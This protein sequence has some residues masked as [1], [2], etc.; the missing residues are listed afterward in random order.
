MYLQNKKYLRRF[1]YL[2]YLTAVT[3]LA[4]EIILR[5][6]YPFQ[7]KI[8]GNQWKLSTNVV[9]HLKNSNNPRLDPVVVN[10]RNSIGFRGENPSSYIDSQ[11]TLLTVGGSTTACT[12]LTEG[13]TWTDILGKKLQEQFPAAWINNAG[14]DGHSAYGNV[15]FLYHYLPVLHFK[16]R[17]I[18][19]LVGANDIDR[20]D[21]GSAD[22]AL[23][24][25]GMARRWLENNSETVN[26]FLDVKRSLYPMNIFRGN[27][28]WDFTNFKT[29]FL[30]QQYIDSALQKQEAILAAFKNRLN[31]MAVLC[32]KND[33]LPVFITQ[34]LVFGDG[35][36]KGGSPYLDFHEC[37]PNENGQLLWKKLA[38][39]NEVTRQT[40]QEKKL[41]C[42]DLAGQLPKDTLYFYDMVH[43][44]NA[45]AQKVAEIIYKDL[46]QYLL[47]ALPQYQKR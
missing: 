15:N 37:H 35:T 22:T 44:T 47:K 14:L 29:V 13:K 38:L 45:G 18:L 36:R 17:V 9:Y 27:P 30:T 20:N 41:H 2:F 7:R 32:Q 8:M 23:T 3:V 39:Y 6:Y 11:L 42:I 12:Y 46:N 4:M 1:L 26:F 21:A 28:A 43:F 16:P 5:F 19:F 25:A 31:D 34:P 33:I 40:A 24:R 10:A